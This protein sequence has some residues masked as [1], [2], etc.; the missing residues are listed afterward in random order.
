MKNRNILIALL[1]YSQNPSQNVNFF[2]FEGITL[3][4][5]ATHF[6]WFRSILNFYIFLLHAI[7]LKGEIEV[8]WYGKTQMLQQIELELFL[9]LWLFKFWPRKVYTWS[10]IYI[11]NVICDVK[12]VYYINLKRY[13][14]FLL[15]S[16]ALLMAVLLANQTEKLH[17]NFK[18]DIHREVEHIWY[19]FIE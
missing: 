6:I 2:L 11:K 14:Y 18:E 7:F 12:Y 1:H 15:H 13:I 5:T 9:E 10:R 17:N 3:V 19:H 4:K 16:V 8:I